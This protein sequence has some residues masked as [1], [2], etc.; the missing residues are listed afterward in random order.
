MNTPS[1]VAWRDMRMRSPRMAPPVY[2]LDGSTATTPTRCPRA[3]YASM[4]RS[5]RVDLPAPGLP[6]TPR[7]V[8]LP[9][10]GQ[11]ALSSSL[12]P[13]A[14]SSTSRIARPIARGSPPSTRVT[15][16]EFGSTSPSPDSR[17]AREAAGEGDERPAPRDASLK[18]RE[19]LRHRPS[20]DGPVGDSQGLA[21]GVARRLRL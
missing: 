12:L 16:S 2:G 3:R 20:I 8:A 17:D 19:L 21:V 6:V 9:V 18:R 14:A 1:S 5:Q 15:R 7:T 13:D 4:S 11:S 10:W